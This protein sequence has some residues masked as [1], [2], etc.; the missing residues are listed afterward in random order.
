M[1]ARCYVWFTFMSME[2]FLVLKHVAVSEATVGLTQ[3]LKE[4]LHPWFFTNFV[5]QK[6]SLSS[7]KNGVYN[8]D[9]DYR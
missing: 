5:Y 1:I 6:Q 4:L 8:H 9:C 3:G 2:S 7:F